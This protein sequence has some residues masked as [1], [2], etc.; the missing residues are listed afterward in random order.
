MQQKGSYNMPKVVEELTEHKIERFLG[1][2]RHV[3]PYGHSERALK[4][5]IF[6]DTAGLRESM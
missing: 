1:L 6:G 3:K 2:G 4:A 5:A